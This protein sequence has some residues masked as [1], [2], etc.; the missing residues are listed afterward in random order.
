MCQQ[1]L[2][3]ALS[4]S[5]IIYSMIM[6]QVFYDPYFINNETGTKRES[7]LFKFSGLAQDETDLDRGL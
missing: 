7:H 4:T 2:F 3:E 6:R 1:A 5:Q